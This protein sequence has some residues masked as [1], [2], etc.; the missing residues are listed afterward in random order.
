MLESYYKEKRTLVDFRRGPLGPHFDGF[1]A[2]LQAKGYSHSTGTGILGRACQF[3]AFLIER[4]IAKAHEITESLLDS[5]LEAYFAPVRAAGPQYS[6][7]ADTRTSV[8]HL[9][10]YLAEI[11]VWKPPNPQATCKPFTWLL[12][13]YLRYLR[14][15]RELSPATIAYQQRQLD[16]FLDRLGQ[17]AVRQRLKRLKAQKIEGLLKEHFQSSTA[18][19]ASL[20]GVLRHFF[21]YCAERRYTQTDFAGLVPTVR[22]YHQAALP[23]G[24]ED[25]ALAKML[26]AVNRET[27]FGARDYAILMLMMAY[28]V[29]GISVAQLLLEDLDWPHSRI[30]IRAQKGG[31]EVVVPLLEAVGEALIQY[32]RHRPEAT[33]FREVFLGLK[34]PFRPLSG[35]AISQV[36]QQ[37][38]KKSGI[39]TTH[40]GARTL[41]HSWALRA[42]AHNSA[43]KSIADVL[44]HRYIDTTFIYAKADLNALREVALPWPGKE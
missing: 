8:K 16:S 10:A 42:L 13:P 40:S 21:H 41:R 29:R 2:H 3:N 25:S 20:S 7:Q 14:S 35:L 15:E 23:K 32:L 26:Q 4:G 9:L 34:A 18:N 19:P 17:K 22:R 38:M 33:P 5:F 1:A 12:N 39:K 28:G 6:P 36:V 31:K 30:R 44:G 11:K 24:M 27:P 37:H 43:I